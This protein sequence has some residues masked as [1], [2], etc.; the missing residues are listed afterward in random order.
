MGIRN[1]ISTAVAAVGTAALVM[2]AVTAPANAAPSPAPPVA[3]AP[4]PPPTDV[5]GCERGCSVAFDRQLPD[6]VRFVGLNTPPDG[7]PGPSVLVYL[8]G[9]EVHDVL[10]SPE[11]AAVMD[12]ACGYA[13]D[14]QRCSVSYEVGA[15]SSKVRTML[16]T[17]DRG[18]EITDHVGGDAPDAYVTDLD[19][20]GR[21]DATVR[22][23]TFDPAY[24]GA[25]QYWETYVELDGAFVH[26][27]CGPLETERSAPPVAPLTGACPHP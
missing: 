23:S 24:A 6:D 1:V 10:A 5:P 2:L 15:H 14:A 12:A 16:L 22:M 4:V 27:G 25:P 18:I 11:P 21:G 19:G 13:G 7:G 8:I 26:T 20:N 3:V 9:G 17:G